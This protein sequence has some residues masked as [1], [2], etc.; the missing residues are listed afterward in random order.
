MPIGLEERH[1]GIVDIVTNT[2]IYFKGSRG[3]ILETGPV[4]E[5][6]VDEVAEARSTLIEQLSNVDDEI[7]EMFLMEETPSQEQLI[8]A[9]RRAT[10]KLDFVPVMMGSA[11]K[12]LT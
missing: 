2:A 12:V 9:I 10:L 6:L 1:E 5:D 8:A 3:E 4:P 7:G 11:F